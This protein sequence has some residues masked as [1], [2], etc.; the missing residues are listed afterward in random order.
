MSS[1]RY[2]T[3]MQEVFTFTPPRRRGVFFHFIALLVIG[4][5]LFW[6]IWRSAQGPLALQ[7]SRRL[8]WMAALVLLLLVLTYTLRALQGA[9]YQLSRDGLVFH[10]GLREI[11]LSA[12]DVLWVAPLDDIAP[13]PAAP[14]IHWPGAWLGRTWR[15]PPTLGRVEY[16]ASGGDSLLAVGSTQGIYVI[17]PQRRQAF[18]ETFAALSE[19]GSTTPIETY[20][21]S[22]GEWLGSAWHYPIIRGLWLLTALLFVVLWLLALWGMGA[23]SQVSLGFTPTGAPRAPLPATSVILLP[24]LYTFFAFLDWISGQFLFRQEENAR[25]AY[26]LWTASVILGGVFLFALVGILW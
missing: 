19:L 3:A 14:W 20:A 4:T 17:S 5:T 12:Y 10:W 22:P 25:M 1:V 24:V 23:R 2:N 16:L 18:L 13:P 8:P 6:Q 7:L 15:T 9:Y 21:V 26:V 11:R